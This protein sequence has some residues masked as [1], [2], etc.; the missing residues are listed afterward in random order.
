[1]G[2]KSNIKR[3]YVLKYIL[4][5]FN[6]TTQDVEFVMGSD[7]M[8]LYKP[9]TKEGAMGKPDEYFEFDDETY[10]LV[11]R[12]AVPVAVIVNTADYA[13]LAD[14]SLS[15]R[16]TS[17]SWSVVV[18]FLVF[19]GSKVHNKIMFAM[20]EFRDKFLG[21][22]DFMVGKEFDYDATTTLPT[23]K[24]YSVV[25]HAT[26]LTASGVVTINGN[27]FISYTLSID[28]ESTDNLIYGNQFE[29]YIKKPTDQAYSRILPIMA[30]WGA[31][32]NLKGEQLLKNTALTGND[33]NKA[34]LTH[35]LVTSRGWAINFT[36]LFEPSRYIVKELFKETYK[37]KDNMNETYFIKMVFKDKSV[38]N[39]V[40]S[41]VTDSTIGFEYECVTGEG[42][43]E[44]VYGDNVIFTIGFAPSWIKA[45]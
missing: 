34:K 13:N 8:P 35:N 40:P 15:D 27:N 16:I 2:I 7:G 19:I 36:L 24:F 21:K 26:D 45:V 37:M 12:Q 20:E 5:K 44:V 39:G 3:D 31:G 23:T 33:L 17:S 9:M 11:R 1:M 14:I 43:T 28:V 41:W 29:F 38:T 6:D 18:E 22:L 10:E 4:D 30:G 32:N 25:T 42:G